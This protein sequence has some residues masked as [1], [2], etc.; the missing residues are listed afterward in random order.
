[1]VPTIIGSVVGIGVCLSLVY[2]TR[3]LS[4]IVDAVDRDAQ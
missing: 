2:I 3:R 1:M 4:E